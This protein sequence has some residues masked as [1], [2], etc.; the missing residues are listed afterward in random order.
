MAKTINIASVGPSLCVKGGISRV[1]ELISA[2]LPAHICLRLIATFNRYTGDKG[3][4]RS[5]RGSRV[6]QV[7]IYLV[8]V[9][10]ILGLALG[11]RT[12]FHVHFAGRGSLLRKGMICVMLRCLR[13]QYAVHSHAADTNLFSHWMPRPGRQLL[14][15]GIGGAGR[16]IVLTQFWHDY[17]SSLLHLPPNRLLLLPNPADLPKSI[18]DRSRRKQLRVLFLGR[19]G[20]RKGAFD[21]IRA[22]AGLPR[23]PRS[24]CHLTMAGDGDTEEVRALARELGCLDRVSIPGWVGK[25][26]VERLLV[27][28]DVLVLPSYAE[29]MAMALVEAMSWGLSVVTTSVGGAAEFLEQGANCLL[30]TPGDVCGITAAISALARDSAFRL[31][32]GHAARETISRFSI[33]SYVCTLTGVYEELAGRLATQ[34]PVIVLSPKSRHEAVAPTVSRVKDHADSA[35]S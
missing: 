24:F 34:N 23:E 9:V 15:W 35:V 3:A 25:A 2:H 17:Y 33:D 29:G 26:E 22:F 13:C 16:V 12:V 28:S 14:L 6:V 27:E 19:I 7:M 31:Q 21:L 10:Q 32:L 4:N 11:R 1:I 30:V 20:V 5:E 8:A 18:P